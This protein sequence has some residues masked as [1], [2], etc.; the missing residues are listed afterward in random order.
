[1]KGRTRPNE[2]SAEMVGPTPALTALVD[3]FVPGS[4]GG[5]PYPRASSLGVDRDIAELV[6]NLPEAQRREFES[7]LRAIDNP[8]LNLLLSG[9]PRRF[10][11]LSS[12]ARER[13]LRAMSRSRLAIKRKGF[14]AGKRLAT[15]FYFSARMSN[16]RHPLWD[17]IHYEPPALPAPTTAPWDLVPIVPA[18]DEEISTDVCV[19]GSGAGGAVLAARAAAAGY[20]VV[21]L[22]AGD[23]VPGLAYPRDE[24]AGFDHLY[25]GRGIVTTS[26]SSI[27]VLA[28]GTPGGGTAI[29]WM[30]CLPPRP[31]ARREW[32]EDAGLIGAD[33]PDFDAAL[34]AVS[35]RLG[36]SRA[37][38][39]VN[40]SNDALLRGCRALGYTQGS[41]WD[42][43]PRNAVGCARRC[44]FCGYGCP[45]SA[46]RS[47]LT[48]FLADAVRAGTRLYCSTRAELVEVDGGRAKAVRGT[49]RGPGGPL[50]VRVRARATVL[51]AGALQT[52]GLLLGSDVKF[53]GVGM[54]LRLDPTASMVGEFPQPVRTWEGPPQTVGVY[55]FQRVDPEAH[56]PWLEVAPAHP[57]LA[58]LATPWAGAH[59]FLRLVERLEFVATPIVLV[60]D[61]GEGRV[62]ADGQGRPVIDYELGTG[63]R[64]N[65]VR[66]IVETARILCA[67]G[68]T[69]LL[70][71]NTPY[72]EAGDGTRPVSTTEL[73][74][75][76]SQ[77]E[78]AGVRKH[79][80]ALFS[81]HPMGSAR[82]GPDPRRSAARP[83]GAVHGVEGLWIG[84]GSLLPSAPGANPMLS[85]MACAW[86]TGDHLLATLADPHGPVGSRPAPSG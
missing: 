64:A 34:A 82:A 76:I 11:R 72:F 65:L 2:E 66:G 27:A 6:A 41:D 74:R 17:R 86:R 75:F 35:S 62:R 69:R 23:W 18:R 7:L 49:Y 19:I 13:Y 22:E 21:V 15:W 28:G 48:T 55:R 36:V 43:L 79:S 80:L 42:I 73:D 3:T 24:R 59:D 26:D 61:T 37:E 54:G 33:G 57:G 68:A 67:A 70:S 78:R 9:S 38:S 44:G 51:A 85:I 46:R 47:T 20:R 25:L 5:A 81:A 40:A 56:G 16:G 32:A 60:R 84:D 31:E 58:A 50:A 39:D 8:W 77:V 1:M 83:T 71:L 53:A 10:T 45:Y 30:T 4:E 29:N 12:E 52:P 63:D 14:Q